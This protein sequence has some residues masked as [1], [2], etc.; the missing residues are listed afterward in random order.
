MESS[1]WKWV[2]LDWCSFYCTCSVEWVMNLLERVLATKYVLV[3]YM[4]TCQSLPSWECENCKGT[5]VSTKVHYS[6]QLVEHSKVQVV[7]Y[8]RKA[9]GWR[10]DRVRFCSSVISAGWQ[11]QS[12][13]PQRLSYYFTVNWLQQ[14]FD[15]SPW[16]FTMFSGSED[17][18][19]LDEFLWVGNS[20]D[21][22]RPGWNIGNLLKSSW[23][24][25][26]KLQLFAA[27]CKQND[28]CIWSD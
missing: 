23:H 11:K 13:L 28:I 1:C 25:P 21:I 14:G 17:N 6:V 5:V 26:K 22:L 12:A 10:D 19:S 18:S 8:R 7:L 27:V 24:V 20:F 16:Y 9:R 2:Y 3:G 15:W 4:T